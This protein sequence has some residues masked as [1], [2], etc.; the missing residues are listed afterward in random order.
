MRA[1]VAARTTSI[2]VLVA[3]SLWNGFAVAEPIPPDPETNKP[4][5]KVDETPTDSTSPLKSVDITEPPPEKPSDVEGYFYRYQE[6]FSFNAGPGIAFNNSDGTS[7]GFTLGN[8]TYL[9]PSPRYFHWESALELATL[10]EGHVWTMARWNVNS[11][12]RWRPYYGAGAGVRL[13]P[14]NGLATFLDV[15]HYFG[16]GAA[17]MEYGLKGHESIRGEAFVAVDLTG[18]LFVGVTIGYNYGF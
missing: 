2:M 9:W 16:R 8:L 10:G 11:T 12:T 6:A 17:G 4:H 3:V 15:S 1:K 5:G 7:T 18:N 13:I 14:Q